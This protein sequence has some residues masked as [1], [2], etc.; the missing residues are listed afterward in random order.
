MARVRGLRARIVRGKQR[1]SG[2]QGNGTDFASLAQL[3][4][5]FIG[6]DLCL[7]KR[8]TT[9]DQATRIPFRIIVIRFSS[10]IKTSSIF[11]RSPLHGSPTFINAQCR[12]ETIRTHFGMSSS[13]LYSQRYTSHLESLEF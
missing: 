9:P 6:C 13:L 8:K 2:L 5:L 10:P 3:I 4:E 11:Y 1:V 7:A 12:S